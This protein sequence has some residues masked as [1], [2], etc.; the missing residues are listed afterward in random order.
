MQSLSL[1]EPDQAK[2]SQAVQSTHIQQIIKTFHS[3]IP[4]T[5]NNA[6]SI[7]NHT[8]KEMEKLDELGK[9]DDY[10]NDI[11]PGGIGGKHF[12]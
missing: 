4:T 11:C 12:Y 2:L 1:V 9:I 8:D 10:I 5:N 6:L 3:N 7:T